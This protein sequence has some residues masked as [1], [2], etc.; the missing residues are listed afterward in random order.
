MNIGNIWRLDNMIKQ[1]LDGLGDQE[2]EKIDTL[3]YNPDGFE[4]KQE[5]IK[6]M[7]DNILNLTTQ[8]ILEL[9]NKHFVLKTSFE[10]NKVR[11]SRKHIITK[12]YEYNQINCFKNKK[13]KTSEISKEFYQ[14]IMNTVYESEDDP[15]NQRNEAKPDTLDPVE[16]EKFFKAIMIKDDKTL[17]N[18]TNNKKNTD[19]WTFEE[20]EYDELKRLQT[21]DIEIRVPDKNVYEWFK[22]VNNALKK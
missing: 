6:Q 11:K 14:K 5:D 21:V 22:T 4:N 7:K 15:Y 20:E 10:A 3:Y 18:L 16:V 13:E 8:E 2:N 12:K 9:Q 1:N 19:F 17:I